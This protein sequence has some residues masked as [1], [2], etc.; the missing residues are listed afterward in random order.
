M[1]KPVILAL[2]VPLNPK[3]DDTL[4]QMSEQVWQETNL[5]W[6]KEGTAYTAD[7]NT[8]EFLDLI[9]SE[10]SPV[11]AVLAGHMH[12][13]NTSQLTENI[14]QYVFDATYKGSIGILN[15]QGN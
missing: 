15:I 13:K 1:N 8:A 5:T 7:T 4:A 9:Y 6:D 10:N 3:M 11:K 2:H 14:T 12:F